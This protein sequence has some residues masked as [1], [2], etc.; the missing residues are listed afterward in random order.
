MVQYKAL[1]D[2]SLRI[3]GC[4]LL[5]ALLVGC[6][7]NISPP[8]FQFHTSA[9]TLWGGAPASI[10]V[11]MDGAEYSWCSYPNLKDLEY[12]KSEGVNLVRLPI[13]WEMM[14]P[15]LDGPLNS[16]YFAELKGFLGNAA[17]LGI[18]VVIDLH[19]SG[20]YNLNWAKDAAANS[21]IEAPDASD[22]SKLGSASVPITAFANFWYQ[23]ATATKGNPAL[24]GYDIMNEPNKMP[25]ANTW[26]AAAQ[27]AVNAIRSADVITPIIVEGDNWASAQNWPTININLKIVDSAN[28][29]I[30]SAHQYFDTSGGHYVKSYIQE[31]DTPNTGV[32][33][34]APFLQWLQANN[35]KGYVGELGVPSNDPQWIPLLNNVLNVLQANGVPATIWNFAL[36]SSTDPLWW[37]SQIK[38]TSVPE[39]LNIAPINGQISPVMALIFQH[40]FPAII[41]YSPNRG[42][43]SDNMTDA[44]VLTLTGLG[45]GDSTVNVY[46]GAALL[47]TTTSNANGAWN[48]MTAVLATGAHSF[49]AIEINSSGDISEPSSALTVTIAPAIRSTHLT[50]PL[51]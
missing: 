16:T 10:G 26:P 18:G 41:S 45:A 11:N 32:Q 34:I 6:A 17:S 1:A 46:D 8:A 31:G 37:V 35:F 15:K 23:L 44:S 19:N 43:V 38:N 24:A 29:I 12:V 5:L 22:A 48:F 3:L 28:D 50:A 30:F 9:E 47:G 27:A 51:L 4:I 2:S 39:N 13:A 14:Q 25:T 36:P 33:E 21:G 20:T 7:E 42:T 49:T 40:S